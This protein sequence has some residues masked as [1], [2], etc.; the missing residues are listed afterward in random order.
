MVEIITFYGLILSAIIY[1]IFCAIFKLDAYY[2]VISEEK[3]KIDFITWS[4]GIYKYFGLLMTMLL[5]TIV[6]FAL[7]QHIDCS[8]D[9]SGSDFSDPI[10]TLIAIHSLLIFVLV[11]MIFFVRKTT[12]KNYFFCCCCGSFIPFT[13]YLYIGIATGIKSVKDEAC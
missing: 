12:F 10:K 4:E 8:L 13:M 11:I 3:G 1:L 9:G 2:F 5:V 7:E 6:V